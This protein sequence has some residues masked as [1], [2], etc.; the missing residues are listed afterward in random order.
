MTTTTRTTVD[1]DE[2]EIKQRPEIEQLAIIESS[3]EE[4][5][6]LLSAKDH[7][8]R[9]QDDLVDREKKK[10]KALESQHEE[11]VREL[12]RRGDPG[13]ALPLFAPK[14]HTNGSAGASV[15]TATSEPIEQPG[16]M[17]LALPGAAAERGAYER[18][19]QEAAPE[20]CICGSL[21]TASAEEHDREHAKAVADLVAEIAPAAAAGPRA[22]GGVNAPGFP[23]HE[24]ACGKIIAFAI[25]P[26]L[27]AL[28]VDVVP[29]EDGEYVVTGDVEFEGKTRVQL[30]LAKKHPAV[31]QCYT[32][33]FKTC[34]APGRF[35]RNGGAT[36]KARPK[37]S[38]GTGVP[39]GR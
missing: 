29:T 39:H 27:K 22:I 8:L 6:A 23:C 28:P 10:L 25:S 31:A 14:P 36:K 11:I 3:T 18:I 7:E 30:A 1:G 2:A 32:S 38:A 15:A 5:C 21:M 19:P 34:A 9:D 35:S 24:P 13:R 20:L 26:N 17:R 37:L 33:H 12:A 16:T 4:L